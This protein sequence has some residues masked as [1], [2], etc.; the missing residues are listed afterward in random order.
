MGVRRAETGGQPWAGVRLGAR[1]A[2]WELAAE[3]RAAARARALTRRI[4]REWRV[5]GA[6][7]VDDVV[8]VVDELVT[9]AVT[10]GCGPVRLRLMV[11]G[12]VLVGEVGDGSPVGPRRS[13]TDP[14]GLD[15]AEAGRGL[16]LVEALVAE[17]G[18]RVEGAG[19]TVWFSRALAGGGPAGWSAG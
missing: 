6:E 18:V 10:H 1:V 14:G 9:N 11:D 2:V 19:K 15:W 8:L 12:G 7:D 5:A 13:G 17:Y 4:L 3:V 16:L